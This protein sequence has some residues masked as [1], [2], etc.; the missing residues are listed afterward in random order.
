M[1][2]EEKIKELNSITEKLEDPS[3]PMNE[4]VKLYETG[5][6]IAKECFQELTVVKGKI[7]VIKQD[8]EKY[9]EESFE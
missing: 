2:F 4:G 9:K 1:N 3:L 8:L 5:V 7:N 6:A